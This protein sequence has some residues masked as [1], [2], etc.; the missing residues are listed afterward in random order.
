M[1]K[2]SPVF[3]LIIKHHDISTRVT[4]PTASTIKTPCGSHTILQLSHGLLYRL[5]HTSPLLLQP[6]SHFRSTVF[7]AK[8][9]RRPSLKRRFYPPIH[10]PHFPKNPSR[11]HKPSPRPRRSV[12]MGRLR[13]KLRVI[14]VPPRALPLGPVLARESHRLRRLL[15]LPETRMQQQHL[16]PHPRQH[17]HAH[18]DRR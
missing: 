11:P 10:H 5:F 14:H 1:K 18:S 15:L 2:I 17:R 4:I 6:L 7:P 3:L 12:L 8:S 9:P 16:R 13:T